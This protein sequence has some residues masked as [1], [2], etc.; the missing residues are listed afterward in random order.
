M[1]I[2]TITHFWPPINYLHNG[3]F[4]RKKKNINNNFQ[5]NLAIIKNH[6]ETAKL[7]RKH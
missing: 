7:L 6:K 3:N 4:I 1:Q 2:K 5:V